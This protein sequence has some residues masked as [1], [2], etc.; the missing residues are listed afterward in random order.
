MAPPSLCSDESTCFAES[1]VGDADFGDRRRTRAAVRILS[2]LARRCAG[3]VTAVFAHDRAGQQAAY[4][5]LE[6][7]QVRLQ[8]LLRALHSASA[9]RAACSP[10]V[11]VPVDGTDLTY[12]DSTGRRGTGPIADRA[13]PARGFFHVGALA[14]SPE[15]ITLGLCASA[16]WARSDVR[17][18]RDDASRRRPFEQKESFAYEQVM[19]CT[20]GLLERHAPDTRPWFQ[21]DRGGDIAE[22]LLASLHAERWITVR[23]SYDRKVLAGEARLLGELCARTPVAFE[24]TLPLRAR[25]GRAARTARVQVSFRPVTL[26]LTERA[27]QHQWSAS[28][29]TVWVR[30]RNAPAGAEPIEWTLHTSYP[31]EDERDAYEV[32][33]G[34]C[35][36]WRIEEFHRAWKSGACQVERSQLRSPHALWKWASLMSAEATRVMRM[37]DLSRSQPDAPATDM[38][39]EAEIEA[40]VAL[41]APRDHAPGQ[42]PTLGRVVRWVAEL[43]G[44]A[45][46]GKKN[47]PGVTVLQRGMDRV[48]SVVLALE[49]MRRLRRDQ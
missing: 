10:V 38:F 46:S 2:A 14:I 11:Y 6:N 1:E 16:F 25:D 27:S 30:E 32:V 17:F 43:G 22:L 39:S 26:W 40:I 48:E 5:W 23:G 18:V 45:G 34:Y 20:E 13:H 33:W 8:P 49:N 29:W 15:G 44:Y 42:A 41:R 7:P 24:A 12:E 3:T 28:V 9:R 31:V 35:Q 4:D 36:R 19:R 37:R 21:V 47:P